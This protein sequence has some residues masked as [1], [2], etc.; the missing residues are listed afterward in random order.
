VSERTRE[1]QEANVALAREVVEHQQAEARLQISLSEK[2]VLIQEV[3]H[4]VKNNLQDVSSLL[5]L[6]SRKASDAFASELLLESQGRVRT[7]A[8]IHQKLYASSDLGRVDFRDYLQTLLKNLFDSYRVYPGTITLEADVAQ[9]WLD[10]DT[11]VPCGLI[12][13]EVVSNALK[14]AFPDG[15][16]GCIRV[17]LANLDDQTLRLAVEDDGVGLPPGLDYRRTESLGLQLAVTLTHQLSGVI[18]VDSTHGVAF[19][20]TFA[21]C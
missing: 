11:A 21:A 13:N 16:K 12:V 8:L 19:H 10:I 1:L 15:R 9:A 3:H 20:T 5:G 7:M 17:R 2:E 14:H 18:A 6:Q 4:R